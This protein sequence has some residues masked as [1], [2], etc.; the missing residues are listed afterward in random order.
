[1]ATTATFIA[2][3]PIV[4]NAGH[5]FQKRMRPGKETP[6]K[7]TAEGRHRCSGTRMPR[8]PRLEATKPTAVRIQKVPLMTLNQSRQ[9][10]LWLTANN[11]S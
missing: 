6:A 8:N 2:N 3:A 10:L 9:P 4:L 1:M 5:V 7:T 11:R